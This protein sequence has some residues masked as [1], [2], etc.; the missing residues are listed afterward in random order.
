MKEQLL[1]IHEEL[2]AG[3][4]KINIDNEF[5]SVE[6]NAEN[7]PYVVYKDMVLIKQNPNINSIYGILARDYFVTTIAKCGVIWAYIVDTDIKINFVLNT[8]GNIAQR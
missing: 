2:H 5:L 1:K 8:S 3:K 7:Q 4:S 6:N